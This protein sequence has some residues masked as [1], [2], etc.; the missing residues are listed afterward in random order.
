MPRFV[1][2]IKVYETNTHLRFAFSSLLLSDL[3]LRLMDPSQSVVD[4]RTAGLRYESLVSSISLYIVISSLSDHSSVQC[5]HSD[6]I[7]SL[8][9][10]PSNNTDLLEMST[11]LSN[12]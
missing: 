4:F 12:P 3:M 10:V 5:A 9:Q 2:T 6:E 11:G 1:C 8:D 7:H